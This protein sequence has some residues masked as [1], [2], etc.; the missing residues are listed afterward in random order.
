MNYLLMYIF[1][2]DEDLQNNILKKVVDTH[3][4]NSVQMDER[5]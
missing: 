4:E 3:T 1:L 5:V 2:S